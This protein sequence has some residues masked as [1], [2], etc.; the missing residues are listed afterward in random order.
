MAWRKGGSGACVAWRREKDGG[1]GV[2]HGGQAVVA[3]PWSTGTRAA[4]RRAGE[5][6]SLSRGLG[7]TVTGDAV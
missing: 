3:D 7:A 6:G 1:G 2:W 4:Q 5:A